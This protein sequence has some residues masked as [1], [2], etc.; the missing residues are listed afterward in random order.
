MSRANEDIKT[1]ARRARLTH[2]RAHIYIIELKDVRRGLLPASLE[3]PV[4]NAGGQEFPL[5][6]L[7][8][9]QTRLSVSYV[10]S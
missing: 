5:I 8:Q 10:L 2:L 4:D 9:A 7:Y 3:P 1:D 6:G